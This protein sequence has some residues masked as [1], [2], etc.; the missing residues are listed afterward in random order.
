MRWVPWFSRVSRKRARRTAPVR[1]PLWT[2]MDLPS[3]MCLEI[4]QR[5]Q[6]DCEYPV[7]VCAMTHVLLSACTHVCVSEFDDGLNRYSVLD[8]LFKFVWILLL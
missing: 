4:Y 3:R 5:T 6:R 2:A 7:K 1:G 8:C